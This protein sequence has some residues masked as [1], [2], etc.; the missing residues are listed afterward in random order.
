M[1]LELKPCTSDWELN[2]RA[3]TWSQPKTWLGLE[4]T[5]PGLKPGQNPPS[6]N[7]DHTPGFRTWSSGSW[8]LIAER[9]QWETKWCITMSVYWGPGLVE[10][11]LSAILQPFCSNQFMSSPWAIS[12]LQRLCPVPFPPVSESLQF[13]RQQSMENGPYPLHSWFLTFYQSPDPKHFGLNNIIS[14]TPIN[15]IS[16][17]SQIIRFLEVK[18]TPMTD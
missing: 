6:Y 3:G 10:V 15:F 9:I 13:E 7:W 8:C 5:Q 2:P 4:P 11:D 12:F 14:V 17:I 1:T 16:E 18:E